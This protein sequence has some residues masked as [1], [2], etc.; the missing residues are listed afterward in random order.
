MFLR[1]LSLSLSLSPLAR[2]LARFLSLRMIILAVDSFIVA[3]QRAFYHFGFAALILPCLRVLSIA[4]QRHANR[5]ETDRRVGDNDARY[6]VLYNITI[7][8]LIRIWKFRRICFLTDSQLLRRDA[9]ETRETKVSN[10]DA[11]FD[12]ILIRADSPSRTR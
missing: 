7:Q 9:S 10:G 6:I 4:C 12:I 11:I 2:S 8:G 5:A 3:L 1:R